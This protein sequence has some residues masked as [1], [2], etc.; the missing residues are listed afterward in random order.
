MCQF[1]ATWLT[2]CL[3][4]S[5]LAQS[6]RLLLGGRTAGRREPA[7]PASVALGSET[8]RHAVH[9]GH[10]AGHNWWIEQIADSHMR[11]GLP[12]AARRWL[13]APP[14]TGRQDRPPVQRA[15]RRL[16]RIGQRSWAS[17]PTSSVGR[18]PSTVAV[19]VIGPRLMGA[20]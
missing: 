17:A 7:G 13:G 19:T 10:Y 20:P 2:S 12:W 18:S 3:L 11:P 16:G 6:F 8:Q 14:M 15:V 5:R 1:G 9:K 4:R